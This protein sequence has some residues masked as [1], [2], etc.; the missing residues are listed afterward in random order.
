MTSIKKPMLDTTAALSF[1]ES[2]YQGKPSVS[3]A[4]PHKAAQRASQRADLGTGSSKRK[5]R[6]G[7][8]G[9]VPK[10]Y[11]RLTANIPT[12]LHIK[13]KIKAAT[14]GRS[15]VDILETLLAKHL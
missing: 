9:L 10:G 12:D 7:K 15:I 14:E 11:T 3:L 4:K 1:A 13:L 6:G 2:D 8:S 5:I